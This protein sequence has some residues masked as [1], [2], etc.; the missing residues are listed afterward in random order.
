[1]MC[2]RRPTLRKASERNRDEEGLQGIGATQDTACRCYLRGPDGVSGLA[3]PGYPWSAK[4]NGAF[5][6]PLT[7]TAPSGPGGGGRGAGPGAGSG[8]VKSAPWVPRLRVSES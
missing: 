3:P 7:Q 6:P 4:Y 1:M 5:S 8:A 2:G